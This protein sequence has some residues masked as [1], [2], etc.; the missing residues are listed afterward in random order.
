MTQDVAPSVRNKDRDKSLAERDQVK[1]T[2]DI[3]LLNNRIQDRIGAATDRYSKHIIGIN[4]W[5]TTVTDKINKWYSA[6][7][8]AIP[9]VELGEYGHDKDPEQVSALTVVVAYLRY[10]L[11]QVP[12]TQMR[13]DSWKQYN[14]NCKFAIAE[15]NDFAATYKWGANKS[16]N[17]FSPDAD[18]QL[19]AGIGSVYGLVV[20][21][22][23]EARDITSTAKG[24][25]NQFETITAG[26]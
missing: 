12:E 15:L 19:A 5:V 23:E 16:D 24:Y 4:N 2:Q 10:F 18:Q 3:V 9:V 14:S 8:A 22:T 7:Y 11:V 6:R 13:Y 21:L 26:K 20:Q 17:I 1:F 25:Q